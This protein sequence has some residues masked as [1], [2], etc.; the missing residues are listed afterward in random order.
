MRYYHSILLIAAF[1]FAEATALQSC[2]TSKYQLV[3]QPVKIS[4]NGQKVH[5]QPTGKPI[6]IGDTTISGFLIKYV[7]Q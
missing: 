5:V 1:A 6:V 4:T 7:R 3:A 2:H